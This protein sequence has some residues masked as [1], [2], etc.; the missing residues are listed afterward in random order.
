MSQPPRFMML[1]LHPPR[2]DSSQ[3][4]FFSAILT[5]SSKLSQAPLATKSPSP[6]GSVFFSGLFSAYAYDG[7]VL[8]ARAN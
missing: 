2:G 3:P 4:A 6:V 1:E 7:T 8:P 5:A